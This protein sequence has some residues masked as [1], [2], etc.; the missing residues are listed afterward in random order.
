MQTVSRNKKEANAVVFD[1]LDRFAS[2]GGH[3]LRNK[4]K[5]RWIGS[6][7]DKDHQRFLT[8][9]NVTKTQRYGATRRLLLIEVDETIYA[10]CVGFQSLLEHDLL[11]QS[12]VA[13]A[14]ATVILSELP[15]EPIVSAAEVNNIVGGT[16]ESDEDYEGHAVSD[17]LG[18]FPPLRLYKF[19][20]VDAAEAWVVFWLLCLAECAEGESWIDEALAQSLQS[21]SDDREIGLPFEVLARSVF[22]QDPGSLFLALYRCIE[23]LY[24]YD[25]CSQL[26]LNLEQDLGVSNIEWQTLANRLNEDLSWYPQ[27]AAALNGLLRTCDESALEGVLTCF[28][29]TLPEGSDRFVACGK[30]IYKLRNALVH[31]RAGQHDSST[32]EIKWDDLCTAMAA[33][34]VSLYAQLTAP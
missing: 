20:D 8:H 5:T 30:R 29:E 19:I 32:S 23:A 9:S 12:E 17:L 14:H 7:E 21:L 27:E 24:A 3:A 16:D 13:G 33:L 6:S 31:F 10:A 25:A 4:G 18:I 26:A 28:D 2:D 15:I 11:A 1:R 22:D 34:I